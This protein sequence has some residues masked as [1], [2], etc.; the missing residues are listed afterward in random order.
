MVKGSTYPI[1]TTG[2][3]STYTLSVSNTPAHLH[4]L[5]LLQVY[6]SAYI[7]GT[8]TTVATSGSV[9]SI[10]TSYAG[11]SGA[12]VVTLPPYYAL[13]FIIKGV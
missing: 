2:G 5:Y 11:T 12:T 9:A 8:Y 1:N 3:A 10:A 6:S 4:D 13:Y 7:S